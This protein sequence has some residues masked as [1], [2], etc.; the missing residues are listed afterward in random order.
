MSWSLSVPQSKKGS[1]FEAA[2]DAAVSTG[3]DAS[4]PGVA[5]DV[6]EAKKALKALGRRIKRSN[7]GG[8]AS[9]HSL[10][11]DEGS[12]WSDSVSVSVY[13]AE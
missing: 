13:G 6:A 9:G 1:E 11:A 4:L 3:Q 8:S 7:I 2:V 10:Q 5:V 12:N